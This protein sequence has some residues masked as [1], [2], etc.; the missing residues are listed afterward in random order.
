MPGDAKPVTLDNATL[1]TKHLI[2]YQQYLV[3]DQNFGDNHFRVATEVFAQWILCFS[4]QWIQ[5]KMQTFLQPICM[6]WKGEYLLIHGVYLIG[7]LCYLVCRSNV[8]YLNRVIMRALLHFPE[9]FDYSY[10]N[11]LLWYS[12]LLNVHTWWSNINVWSCCLEIMPA[13]HF[14]LEL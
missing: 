12:T 3:H 7:R 9:N 13:I 2:L 8:G 1:G 14:C 4:R 11:C 5:Q 10:K 6:S